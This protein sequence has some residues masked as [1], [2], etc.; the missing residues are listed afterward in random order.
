MDYADSAYSLW[1]YWI[2]LPEPFHPSQSLL[3]DYSYWDLLRSGLETGYSGRRKQCLYILVNSSAFMEDSF[4][5]TQSIIGIGEEHVPQTL[6]TKYSTIFKIIV[7]DR[8]VN[9]IADALSE[10]RSLLQYGSGFPGGFITAL[11]SSSLLPVM[12]DGVRKIVGNFVLELGIEELSSLKNEQ[13][14]IAGQAPCKY[15]VKCSS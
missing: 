3:A 11:L 12:S 6:W 14:F 4:T 2:A 9:Q 1:A 7:L 13:S 5:T 8:A 10:L 15:I